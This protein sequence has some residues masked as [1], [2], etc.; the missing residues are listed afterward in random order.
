MNSLKN[1]HYEE[2]LKFFFRKI[3]NVHPKPDFK[4]SMDIL[5]REK[6]YCF[7]QIKK[8]RSTEEFWKICQHFL[9]IMGDGHTSIMLS[10]F[11]NVKFVPIFVLPI[12][13]VFVIIKKF[14]T[15]YESELEKINEGDIVLFIDGKEIESILQEKLKLTTYNNFGWAKYRVAQEIF[16]F[17]SPNKKFI[18]VVL[19]RKSGE[20]YSVQIPL[21]TEDELKIDEKEYQ[22]KL[23][24]NI[25]NIEV[26]YFDDIKTGYLKY[27]SCKDRE[28]IKKDNKHWL[29]ELKKL[30]LEITDIPDMEEE[31][32][33][34]FQELQ[35][36]NYE[37]LII[38]IR[39]NMGG[40]S[41][42]AQVLFKYLTQKELQT[43]DCK[44]KISKEVK[45][46]SNSYESEEIGTLK[47][48]DNNSMKFPYKSRLEE[49]KLA[50]LNQFGGKVFILIDQA[51]FSSGEWL[52]VELYANDLGTFIGEPTGG[53]GEVP[54]D[55]IKFKL[56]NTK[57]QLYVSYKLF[58]P[59][60]KNNLP[61]VIPHIWK[62][63]SLADYRNNEDTV[64]EFV[65][66]KIKK[67]RG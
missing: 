40:N 57:L 33:K 35:E 11:E 24:E 39:G 47:E 15:K 9:H 13:G 37:N 26:K 23:N 50:E 41:N 45:E 56:P 49:E 48:Y 5:K 22:D 6:D 17:I 1:K 38:D 62:R 21:V 52:A 65:K 25:K 27:N 3:F 58:T 29:K 54:G 20:I 64:L 4:V 46:R 43:Y 8:C 53:G 44:I 60:L 28:S 7:S 34:L 14:I 32:W 42:V 10:E 30:N 51:I 12:E 18:E 66:N 2:D 59:P 31:C 16:K 63:Q 61:G 36:R 67:K 19:A 55:Q